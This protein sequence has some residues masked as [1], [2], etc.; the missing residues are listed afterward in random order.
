[1]LVFK[2]HVI[3]NVFVSTCLGIAL[4]GCL[5]DP[6]LMD[7]PALP[8]VEHAG[9]PYPKGFLNRKWRPNSGLLTNLNSDGTPVQFGPGTDPLVIEARRFYNT[10]K[11]PGKIFV[12]V[13]YPDPFSGLS[14]LQQETAPLTFEDWKLT[15]G[16]PTWNRKQESLR[17]YRDRIGAVLYYNQYELGLGREL[18]C[19]TFDDDPTSE[20][21]AQ[22]GIACFVT[23]YGT[24]FSDQHNSLQGAIDGVAPKNTVCITF[25]PSFAP[26]YQVQFYVYGPTGAR[27]EWAQLDSNGP[28]PVP[29]VCMNCHGGNYDAQ[30]HLA[31]D[32][33][34]LPL[35]PN[36]VSFASYAKEP[37]A[38]REGQEEI[39]R[40]V[41]LMNLNSP[42]TEV[43]EENFRG[44]Y[45]QGI[46]QPGSVST[47]DFVPKGWDHSPRS[48]DQFLKII[49]PYC[50]TCHFAD[51]KAL[52]G[53]THWFYEAFRSENALIAN[54]ALMASVC[55][56][57]EMP[58]AQPTLQYFWGVDPGSKNKTSI[59]GTAY[60][61]P[62][63]ALLA[64]WNQNRNTCGG[65]LARV[66]DCRKSSDPTTVCGNGSS[67]MSCHP[68]TGQ[69]EP[70]LVANA[71]ER[72]DLPTGVCHTD[73]SLHCASGQECRSSY[74]TSIVF[75]NLDGACFTCGREGQP[76]CKVTAVRCYEGLLSVDGV[77][78]F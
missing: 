21:A 53:S 18:A 64:V 15:F 60:D 66:M 26:G 31:K 42:L 76:E 12:D 25:R 43:Q 8:I 4:G 63:D 45:P 68:Q 9:V 46:D 3:R 40:Q 56:S 77:C 30:L 1:M 29:Q 48:K 6:D 52:D 50:G 54:P 24:A 67:G 33:R 22:K 55:N 70:N 39:I 57:F 49:K 35:D 75:P 2:G 78:R 34:F 69:C 74:S 41:N 73:G 36:V 59:D 16:F 20:G 37:R 13:N 28:R 58:N 71:P 11:R 23:N 5:A 19:M 62:V 51:Q 17:Q 7:D 27:Q 72:M 47:S 38:S 10:L 61:A 32:A 65:D 44:L 14:S